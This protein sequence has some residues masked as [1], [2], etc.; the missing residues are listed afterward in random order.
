MEWSEAEDLWDEEGGHA[1]RAGSGAEHC[2][3]CV[4]ECFP[5]CN[6]NRVMNRCVDSS[7]LVY[8]KWRGRRR[9]EKDA[10][11]MPSIRTQ[12]AN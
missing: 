4:D 2:T 1:H 7:W 6:G 5:P 10:E 9:R 8:L 12:A 11:S 3:R